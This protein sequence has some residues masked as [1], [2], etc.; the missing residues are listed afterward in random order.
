MNI[1]FFHIFVYFLAIRMSICKTDL[2]IANLSH[3]SFR[4]VRKLKLKITR[5]YVH[6]IIYLFLPHIGNG[7]QGLMVAKQGLLSLRYL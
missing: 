4:P 1:V 3:L 2:L 6:I 7:I 5:F